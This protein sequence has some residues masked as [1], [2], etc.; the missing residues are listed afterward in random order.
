MARRIGGGTPTQV[1]RYVLEGVLLSYDDAGILYVEYKYPNG[2]H[3][4][5]K[6]PILAPI[7][8]KLK[9]RKNA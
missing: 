2:K 8:T 7:I 3:V 1:I 6:A 4:F 5:I 9:E